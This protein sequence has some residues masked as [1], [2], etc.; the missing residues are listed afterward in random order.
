MFKV[1]HRVLL[2]QLHK[3]TSIGR[4]Q[5]TLIM[6]CAF[7]LAVR[8]P[9]IAH[10]YKIINVYTT[11]VTLTYMQKSTLGRI[12]SR[13]QEKLLADYKT[14]ATGSMEEVVVELK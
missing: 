3:K 2:P 7:V 1:R 5:V 9:I 14:N 6:H 8:Y 12:L 11:L 10:V 13:F 4:K